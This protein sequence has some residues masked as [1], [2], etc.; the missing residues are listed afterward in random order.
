MALDLS[1]GTYLSLAP[2]S[3]LCFWNLFF[4]LLLFCVSVSDFSQR[5]ISILVVDFAYIYLVFFFDI[6]PAGA[7]SWYRRGQSWL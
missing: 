3:P 6:I 2:L 4:L 5:W 7:G 1:I